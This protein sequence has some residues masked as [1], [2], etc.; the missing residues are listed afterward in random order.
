MAGLIRLIGVLES[1]NIEKI[2]YYNLSYPS[3]FSNILQAGNSFHSTQLIRCKFD[4]YYR[5]IL[6][7]LGPVTSRYL[8]GFFSEE[9]PVSGL[10]WGLFHC[11]NVIIDAE[12]NSG[13]QLLRVSALFVASDF[14][15]H[16]EGG[17]WV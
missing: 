12:L 7:L 17:I 1:R 6:V 4:Q 9:A 3:G 15:T 16:D 8:V 10:V 11:L 5:D 13:L 14:V 2:H